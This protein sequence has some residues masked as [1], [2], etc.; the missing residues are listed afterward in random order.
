MMRKSSSRRIAESMRYKMLSMLFLMSMVFVSCSPQKKLAY[1]FVKQSRGASVALYLPDELKKTNL[2]EDCDPRLFKDSDLDEKQLRDTIDARTKIL[3]K[4][5][6]DIFL[7]V[8]FASFKE[9]LK[10]YDLKLEYDVEPDSL[11]WIVDLSHIEVQE[12]TP[13][14]ISDCGIE[15]NI[16]MFSVTGINVA[17]WFELINGEKSN[18][19]FNEQDYEEYLVDCYYS[20]DSL[21]NFL[22]NIRLNVITIEGFYDFA[23]MLGRLYAGYTYDFFMNEYVKK[24]MLREEK[25][26]SDDIYLRYDPYEGYVYPTWRDR[27]IPN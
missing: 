7:D 26:C 21:N 4:I 2:R 20:L 22:T 12:K 27:L 11:H 5:D 16:D 14:L 9:T 15:G 8:L 6:D 3:N 24:E 13:T 17:S 23:V 19:L 18:S 1:D 25:D 10:D